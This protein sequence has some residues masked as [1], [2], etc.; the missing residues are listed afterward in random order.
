MSSTPAPRTNESNRLLAQIQRGDPAQQKTAIDQLLALAEESNSPDIFSDAAIGLNH[1][2]RFDEAIDILTQ[3]VEKFPA[4]DTYRVNLAT[5]YGQ[6][7]CFDLC[8]C[9]LEYLLHHSS[10]EEVRDLAHAQTQAYDAFLGLDESNLQLRDLQWD[11]LEECIAV[12]P[13]VPRNYIELARLMMHASKSEPGSDL[14]AGAAEVL[15]RGLAACAD[16]QEILEN[17]CFC[18]FHA[19]QKHRMNAIVKEL[20]TIAPD[21]R[22]LETLAGVFRDGV[23]SETLGTRVEMLMQQVVSKDENLSEAA[24]RDMARIVDTYSDTTSYRL[25]YAF[26]LGI[27]GRME[28]AARQAVRLEQVESREHSFHFNLGQIFWWSGD[29]ERGR[30][31]LQLAMQYAASDRERQDA[32]DRMDELEATA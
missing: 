17:L 19:D 21:S 29:P 30:N 1:L 27:T 31:H 22:I 10:S 5:A 6:A 15:D 23:A 7:E 14:F 18:Y 16:R 25:R 28:E 12:D 20:E 3:L 26:C 11:F 9:H 8:R 24:I 13:A 4:E 2:R 32:K